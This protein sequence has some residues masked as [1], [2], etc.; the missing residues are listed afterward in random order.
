MGI[1]ADSDLRALYMSAEQRWIDRWVEGPSIEG[2][3]LH[4]GDRAPD[5][6]VIADDGSVMSLSDV[7]ADSVALVMLW[8]H[9]GCGCGLDRAGRLQEELPAYREAGLNVLIC[10]PGEKERVVAYKEKYGVPVSMYSDPDYSAHRAFGLGHWSVEQV[11]YDSPDEFCDLGAETGR[12]FQADRR[13]QGR[14]LVDDPWMQAGEF[15]VDTSG[16]IR[17]AYLYNYCEDFPD[18]RVFITAARL[19]G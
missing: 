13:S 17:V 1:M 2:R 11:L 14:P 8:R 6:E 3:P 5:V 7:W 18:P 10:A 12:E 4:R 16:T 15:V 9:L 19:A